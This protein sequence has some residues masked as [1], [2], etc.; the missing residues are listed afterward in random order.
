MDCDVIISNIFLLKSVV[1]F[2][3]YGN[4]DAFI[5]NGFLYVLVICILNCVDFDEECLFVN[6]GN[7][8]VKFFKFK[9]IYLGKVFSRN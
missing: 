1:F 8:L 6:E 5:N 9:R 3:N 2:V 4:M 7:I